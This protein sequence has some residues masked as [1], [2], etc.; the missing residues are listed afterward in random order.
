[1]IFRKNN[2]KQGITPWSQAYDKGRL[3][4]VEVLP[5]DLPNA[6]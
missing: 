1:M 4:L 2:K 3:N 5:L 6:P